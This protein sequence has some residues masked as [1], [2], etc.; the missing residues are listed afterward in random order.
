M[1]KLQNLRVIAKMLNDRISIQGYPVTMKVGSRKY[2][3]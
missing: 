2:M 1:C 3:G